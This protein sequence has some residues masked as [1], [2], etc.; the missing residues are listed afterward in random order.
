MERFHSQ[1]HWLA[2]GIP[3]L[4]EAPAPRKTSKGWSRDIPIER[5]MASIDSVC[6][7]LISPASLPWCFSSNRLQADLAVQA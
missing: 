3:E 4:M 2:D 5:T 1:M 6:I 7:K